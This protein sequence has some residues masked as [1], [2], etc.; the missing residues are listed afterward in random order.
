MS[1]KPAKPAPPV[2]RIEP[3]LHLIRDGLAPRVGEALV[4][5]TVG[6]HHYELNPWDAERMALDALELVRKSEGHVFGDYRHTF[7]N[8]SLGLSFRVRHDQVRL[9]FTWMYICAQVAKLSEPARTFEWRG[10][11]YVR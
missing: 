3:M 5:V 8:R 6:D 4:L 1:R 7:S 9:V 11:T 2:F 10:R